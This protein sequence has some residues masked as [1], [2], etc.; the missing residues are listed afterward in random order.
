MRMNVD[1]RAS[2]PSASVFDAT[3]T[4]ID[5]QAS[6][7]PSCPS[8]RTCVRFRRYCFVSQTDRFSDSLFLDEQMKSITYD[9]HTKRVRTLSVH[10]SGQWLGASPRVC[11]AFVRP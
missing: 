5:A 9:G 3:L 10:A 7:C 6:S 11:F 4:A 8:R 1:P 2:S